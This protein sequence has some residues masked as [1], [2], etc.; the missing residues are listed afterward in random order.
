MNANRYRIRLPWRR[1]AVPLLVLL[2][3]V[4]ALPITVLFTAA[5]TQVFLGEPYG[6]LEFDNPLSGGEEIMGRPVLEW[7]DAGF[8]CTGSGPADYEDWTV[9]PACGSSC[10]CVV[11][12]YS[13]E[14]WLREAGHSA[15]TTTTVPSQA[16]SIHL[17]GDSNDGDC[18]VF[19]SLIHI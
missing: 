14:I 17:H 8:T 11:E 13:N 16:V 10:S 6:S 12:G 18:D 4:P 5:N 9:S 15:T 1:T 2:L 7:R 19:L 3:A